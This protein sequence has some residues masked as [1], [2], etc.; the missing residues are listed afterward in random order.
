MFL[1]RH[2]PF[3]SRN[4]WREICRQGHLLVDGRTARGSRRL[5]AGVRL[6]VFHPLTAEPPVDERVEFIA[7]TAGVLAVYKPGNLPMHESGLFRR[8]TFRALLAQHFGPEWEPVHRL[9]RET[10][11][12]VIC[13][14]TTDLRRQLSLAFETR[15][16]EKRYTAI[17]RGD[18]AWEDLVVDQPMSLEVSTRRPRYV[19]STL[20]MNA[21]T[22]FKVVA[23]TATKTASMIEARP[24]TGRPNQIRVH[25]LWTGHSLI[26]DKIYCED[27]R[28]FDAYHLWGDTAK[29]QQLAGFTRHALHAASVVVRHP[30]TGQDFHAQ[31]PL[32]ADLAELW[33]RVANDHDHDWGFGGMP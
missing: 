10:S 20:G 15:A 25:A 8:H 16:V 12:V 33:R 1:A 11:G 14:A 13:G 2:F 30:G 6:A 31:A 4:Q 18:P 9:D 28:V 29:V 24:R 32:P 5:H 7:Q 23:R 21:C 3:H 22:E 27:E 26:G 17:V 19:I